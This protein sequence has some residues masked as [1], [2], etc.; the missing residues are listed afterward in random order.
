MRRFS[1][2][3][4]LQMF[5]QPVCACAWEHN[6]KQLQRIHRSHAMNRLPSVM[7]GRHQICW[8]AG[9]LRA[10]EGIRNT[11]GSCWACILVH[12]V[13]AFDSPPQSCLR[14][15][16]TETQTQKIRNIKPL[17]I[18]AHTKACRTKRT[19]MLNKQANRKTAPVTWAD[20]RN[21]I[22]HL[23]TR[24]EERRSGGRVN[25][26]VRAAFSETD[27]EDFCNN[28]VMWCLC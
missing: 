10:K 7:A 26:S 21:R 12:L 14:T 9:Y 19:G 24:R 23:I 22:F 15:K 1:L 20:N 28:A 6:C 4:Q 3:S 27:Q 5:A 2:E 17:I 18:R 13:Q 16:R 8:G 25:I 11:L